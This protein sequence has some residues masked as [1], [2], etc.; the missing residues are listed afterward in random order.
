[1][2]NDIIQIEVLKAEWIRDYLLEIRFTDE[3][4]Q[5]VDFEQFL[6]N[7]KHPGIQKYLE[8]E[9]FKKFEIRDGNLDWN[10]FDL[11]FPVSDLYTGE[12]TA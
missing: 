1:M 2:D 10:D 4:I 6:K 11:I 8:L 9:L 7:S 5:H 12:I 3:K